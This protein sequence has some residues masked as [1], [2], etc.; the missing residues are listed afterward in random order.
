MNGRQRG[1]TLIEMIGVL[2][3]G[4]LSLMSV[5]SM[6]DT[7]LD[8]A[9]GQQAAMYQAQVVGAATKYINV[10]YGAILAAT[11]AGAGPVVITLDQLKAPGSGVA[12]FLYPGFAAKNA[13]G[14]NTCILVLQSS[15]DKLSALVVTN[16]GDKIEEGSIPAVAAN[17]GSGGG[18]I[19]PLSPTVAQGAAWKM[20]PAELKQ[21]Q[22]AGCLEGKDVDGGHL[23]SAIFFDGPVQQSSDF[24]YRDKV[25]G[26]KDLNTMKTPLFLSGL[27][28]E[29]ESDANCNNV[30][31]STDT[32]GGIST[33]AF[34][35][36][37]SCEGGTW[38][39]QGG[40]Y[41]KDPVA[42]FAFLPNT[43]N[44]DGDVR[45]TRNTNR[46]FSWNAGSSQWIP[47]A[48]DEGGRLKA[49]DIVI[50]RKVAVRA[51]C[52]PSDD[53][54]G[55]IAI[56]DTSG[57]ILSCQSGFWMAQTGLTRRPDL[58]QKGTWIVVESANQ[59]ATDLFG[60][61]FRLSKDRY[62]L[63]PLTGW[64]T[65]NLNTA[66][67]KPG[68]DGLVVAQM[69][70]TMSDRQGLDSIARQFEVESWI[71]DLDTNQMVG[72]VS[73][74]RSV[75][76][77]NDSVS[78]NSTLVQSLPK[79]NGGYEIQAR[80]SWTR[81]ETSDFFHMSWWINALGLTEYETPLKVTYYV[82]VST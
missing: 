67:I 14:Q 5:S 82:D 45:L 63:N 50:E 12:P 78:I 52:N 49:K 25:A 61:C 47:L 48:L 69:N 79:N 60:L 40:R 28:K 30:G 76:L 55:T 31:S 56:D 65:A 54:A 22:K 77:L 39:R 44:E 4:S 2:A 62:G 36:V 19:A 9:K 68:K 51:P 74:V 15:K 26:R 34:G 70:S 20:L 75:K 6:I 29:N 57:A 73:K 18:Y 42:Q 21:F 24:L 8:D 11:A 37:L 17:A 38:R 72:D 46:A 58:V 66:P 33:D 43:G 3:L 64:Q 13:Y 7:T 53:P 81:L 35:R 10:Q 23:V 16:G 1:L 80:I 41:W 32:W 71:V 59:P 27:A